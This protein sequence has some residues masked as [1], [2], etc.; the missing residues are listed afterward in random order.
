M[1]LQYLLGFERLGW[2]VVFLDR[3]DPEAWVGQD[4]EPCAPQRSV[5]WRWL[6]KLL[7]G[8]RFG[9]KWAVLESGTE[10]VVGLDRREVR[11]ILRRATLL[12]DVNGYLQDEELLDLASLKLYLDVDPGFFQAWCERSLI[13]PLDRHD[14]YASVGGNIGRPGCRIPLCGQSWLPVRPPVVLAS[15]PVKKGGSRY[16]TVG[17][18]RGSFA[19]VS[20]GG[21]TYGLR[22]HRLREYAC[23]PR[24]TP[25]QLELA[26][27]IDPAD[28]SDRRLLESGGWLLADPASVAS[29]PDAYRKYVQSARGEFL[30][31]KDIYVRMQSGWFSDRSACYLASSK[32]VLVLDTGLGDAW[33]V[34]L[35]LVTFS[36][37]EGAERALAEVEANFEAHS[38][39]ARRLAEELLDSNRVLT[40]LVRAAGY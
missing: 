7:S 21:D 25:V 11:D 31:P 39:A 37:P 40:E 2:E 28:V 6:C 30:V 24:R 18:W 35:G 36:D 16:S 1:F 17:S 20:L 19:P 4:G 33:P 29:D 12:I 5:Q 32:P 8:A 22:A 23:L 3:L 15:W 9:G 34:G 10:R 27:E 38:G 13:P 14:V 26:L